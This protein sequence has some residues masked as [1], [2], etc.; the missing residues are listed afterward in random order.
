MRQETAQFKVKNEEKVGNCALRQLA[1][2]PGRGADMV[3]DLPVFSM[4]AVL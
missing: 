2:V 3:L 1:T 4:A